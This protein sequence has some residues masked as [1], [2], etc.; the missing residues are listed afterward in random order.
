MT[1][2]RQI[3]VSVILIMTC[4][5]V[6]SQPDHLEPADGFFTLYNYQVEYYSTI[7]E[8]LFKGLADGPEIRFLVKPSFEPESVLDIAFDRGQNKYFL[9]YRICEKMIWSNKDWKNV[10]V[11]EYKK[12]ITK[13]SVDLIKALFKAAIVKTRYPDSN[14]GRFDGTSYYFSY[15]DFGTKS[16]TTWS[17]TGGS[18]MD[19]LVKIG[20][21]M[22][23]LAKNSDEPISLNNP[24]LDK[25]ASLTNDINKVS[26]T[27]N[28]TQIGKSEER[29][30]QTTVELERV[31]RNRF[32]L[33][34]SDLGK[35]QLS[36]IRLREHEWGGVDKMPTYRITVGGSYYPNPNEFPVDTFRVYFYESPLL[37]NSIT[38]HAS[39]ESG[40]IRVVFLE[41]KEPF[42]DIY[43]TQLK[44][45][46]Q[47][48]LR[49]LEN[50]IAQEAGN[51]IRTQEEK[52]V[53][54]RIW[55]TSNGSTITLEHFNNSKNIRMVM[56]KD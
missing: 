4:S 3:L 8:V 28:N 55:K 43:H 19:R 21:E 25:I 38:Y 48:L 2:I 22:V 10:K 41:W 7:R 52:Y 13:E 29:N 35:L 6:K 36:E 39:K 34:L 5:I 56:Y 30:I 16:G 47:N 54:R 40:L 26:P 33:L 45:V 9:I 50:S 18:K 42:M 14:I 51:I 27:T 53:I 1:Q 46:H 15:R 12:E 31:F 24:L 49:F 11:L 17:P 37:E 23:E 20:L 44:E 32:R